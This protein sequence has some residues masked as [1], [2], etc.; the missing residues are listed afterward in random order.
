MRL[1]VPF[2]LLVLLSGNAS[3]GSIQGTCDA[4]FLGSSTLHDFSGTVRSRPFAAPI[5]RDVAGNPGLPPVEVEF[6]VSDMRTGNDSRDE[7]MRGMFQSDRYPVIRAV[8]Q[9][10]DAGKFRE[11]MRKDPGGK[12][13]LDVTLA[14]RGVER[15]IRASAG[16]WKEE[17]GKVAF[18]V[19]FPVSL[20]EFELKPPSVLGLIRVGDRI[21]VKGT[22]TLTVA[23]SP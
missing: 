16:G 22:F 11:R 2:V 3:A 21:D 12:T 18:D 1:R 10:L 9:D 20:K 23:E 4:R 5:S 6:P 15:K 14:I 17:G 13:P 7:K 19:E 8:A